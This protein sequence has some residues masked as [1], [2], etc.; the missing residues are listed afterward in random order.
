MCSFY[1]LKRSPEHP[2]APAAALDACVPHVSTHRFL[3]CVASSGR[4]T[5]S[6]SPECAGFPAPQPCAVASSSPRRP[7]HAPALQA[8]S[9]GALTGVGAPLLLSSW[10]YTFRHR[11]TQRAA[12]A[13]GVRGACWLRPSGVHAVF[14]RDESPGCTRHRACPAGA[15]QQRVPPLSLAVPADHATHRPPDAVQV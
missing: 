4:F 14:T 1:S 10:V 6:V 5:K 9:R 3:S 11:N 7:T 12:T 8:P 15:A 13:H 2:A